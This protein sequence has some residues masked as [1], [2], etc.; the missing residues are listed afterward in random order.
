MSNKIQI[1]R[2]VVI[3]IRQIQDGTA[4]FYPMHIACSVLEAQEA[5]RNVAR[6]HPGRGVEISVNDG[7]VLEPAEDGLEEEEWIKVPQ[8]CGIEVR[9]F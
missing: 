9:P 1:L 6:I 5:L 7:W 3:A 4:K 8:Y 2:Q